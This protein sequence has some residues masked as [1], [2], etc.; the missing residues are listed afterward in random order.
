MRGHS[1]RDAAKEQF[2]RKAIAKFSTSGLTKGQFCK[3]EG[4]SADLF[5]YWSGAI[6]RRDQERQLVE[7]LKDKA[8]DKTFL[9]VMVTELK[10]R[11]RLPGTQQM[12][13]AEIVVAEGS[14]RL[15]NG[16]TEDTFRTL[17][18]VVQGGVR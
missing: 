7:P 18:L 4:L 1:G 11:D 9:P 14:V 10:R 8:M 12:A 15:F 5:R 13:V 2:W 17:W 16:I 6:V 3:R